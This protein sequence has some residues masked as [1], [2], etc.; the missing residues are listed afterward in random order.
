[1]LN[2][3]TVPVVDSGDRNRDV[4]FTSGIKHGEVPTYRS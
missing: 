4:V 3:G 2:I 1:M